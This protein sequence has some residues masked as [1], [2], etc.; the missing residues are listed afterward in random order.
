M[1]IDVYMHVICT[2]K[3]FNHCLVIALPTLPEDAHEGLNRA[4]WEGTRQFPS[5]KT[6]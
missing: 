1:Y 6:Q 2:D 3:P 4:R 5:H